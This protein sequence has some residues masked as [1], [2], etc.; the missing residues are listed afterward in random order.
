[1]SNDAFYWWDG[2]DLVL[3]ILGTPAAARDAIL[4]PRGNQLK[5]SVA[6]A[7]E[8]GKATVAMVK[9]LAREFAV[10][11]ARIEVIFGETNVN[12]QL[13]IRAPGR[14]P[15]KLRDLILR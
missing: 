15:D 3:N 8:Q 2:E 5:V 9:F 1:M 7:P 12:K 14:I 11:V 10:P 13:R 6:T 4:K